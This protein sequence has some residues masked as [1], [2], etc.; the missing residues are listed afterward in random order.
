MKLS[1]VSSPNTVAEPKPLFD[2]VAMP[3]VRDPLT[4]GATLGTTG[5]WITTPLLSVLNKTTGFVTWAD[6]GT[7]TAVLV[8]VHP[9]VGHSKYAL[10][11]VVVTLP[12]HKSAP[13]R[14]QSV[15]SR[16]TPKMPLAPRSVGVFSFIVPPFVQA[17][18]IPVFELLMVWTLV[19]PATSPPI[20]ISASCTGP[21]RYEVSRNCTQLFRISPLL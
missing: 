11:G 18:G 3:K 2:S 14:M 17:V 6:W 15:G 20:L 8:V 19:V 16:P 7:N 13:A 21:Q 10:G 9:E 12:S 1:F 5:N 4:V